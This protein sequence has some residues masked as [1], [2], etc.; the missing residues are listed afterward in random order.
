MTKNDLRVVVKEEV[1]NAVKEEGV[2]L[3][4]D[5]L[6]SVDARFKKFEAQ[7]TEFRSEVMKSVDKIIGLFGNHNEEH[8]ILGGRH[9]QIINL[10]DRMEKLETI[11]PQNQHPVA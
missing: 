6:Q 10:E 2:A 1:I 11:H 7:F 9:K 8:E 3:K 5:I 4:L